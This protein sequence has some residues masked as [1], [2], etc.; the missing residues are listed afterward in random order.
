M[1]TGWTIRLIPVVLIVLA[2]GAAIADACACHDQDCH[3]CAGPCACSSAAIIQS[4]SL[5]QVG[6]VSGCRTVHL[7]PASQTSVT[8]IFQPPKRAS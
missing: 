7:M 6:A 5:D 2:C 8:D 1:A 4:N 3:D